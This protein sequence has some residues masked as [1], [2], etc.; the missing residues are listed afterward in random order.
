[1]A[2]GQNVRTA[3]QGYSIRKSERED[4]YSGYSIGKAERHGFKTV[5][6]TFALLYCVAV[7]LWL[8]FHSG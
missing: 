4:R 5:I 1:M 8:T 6:S 7:W 3:I 2:A